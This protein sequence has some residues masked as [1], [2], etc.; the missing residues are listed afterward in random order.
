MKKTLRK[1]LRR[2]QPVKETGKRYLIVCEGRTTEPRYPEG[3]NRFWQRPASLTIKHEFSSPREIVQHAVQLKAES[4]R[5]SKGDPLW[6]FDAI[7]C[8]FDRDAHPN[9]SEALNQA[10]DNNIKVAFSDPN[11]ELWLL[12]HFHDQTAFLTR[13]EAVRICKE[14]MPGYEKVPD[15]NL[16]CPQFETAARRASALRERQSQN[17]LNRQNPWTEADVF[18]ENLRNKGVQIPDK[19]AA[20]FT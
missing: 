6:E 2:R 3:I 20:T 15:M 10:R 17:N 18:L 9:I 19:R 1:E 11:F 8:F 5:K 12:L 13:Q 4:N 7:W 14:H 16:L